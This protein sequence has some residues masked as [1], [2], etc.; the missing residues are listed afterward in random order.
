MVS[1]SHHCS[2]LVCFG[3]LFGSNVYLTQCPTN[4]YPW[5]SLPLP[6]LPRVMDICSMA[7]TV[8]SFRLL[9]AV[10]YP[11]FLI[12]LFSALICIYL[13]LRMTTRLYYKGIQN[14]KLI[15]TQKKYLLAISS[16]YYLYDH[17]VASSSSQHT[18]RLRSKHS[19]FTQYGNTAASFRHHVAYFDDV[20]VI[21]P[22]LYGWFNGRFR[23]AILSLI[24]P[25]RNSSVN[26]SWKMKYI[27]KKKKKKKQIFYFKG[28]F[29]IIIISKSTKK[30]F[31]Q[32]DLEIKDCWPSSRSPN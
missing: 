24:K 21:N 11:F 5:R 23:K 28:L 31:L 27:Q 15:R 6:S 14:Y 29:F 16:Y 2:Y 25:Q 20:N 10:S 30:S 19:R 17:V 32:S 8:Y 3:Y 7:T 13:R 4:L 12:C 1:H 9:L 26:E 18:P 22:I